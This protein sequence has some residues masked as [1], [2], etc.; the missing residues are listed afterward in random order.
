MTQL[1]PNEHANC[2]LMS[3]LVDPITQDGAPYESIKQPSVQA[4]IETTSDGI[5]IGFEGY[6]DHD[7]LEGYG[8][9]VN[10]E[11]YNDELVV[12]VWSNINSEE[13]THKIKLAGAQEIR[14][15]ADKQ[16]EA[17]QAATVLQPEPHLAKLMASQTHSITKME[18]G[19]TVTFS[20][21]KERL[22]V[23]HA[24]DG[25]FRIGPDHIAVGNVYGALLSYMQFAIRA[26]PFMVTA[27]V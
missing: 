11:Y 23:E 25:E 5:N 2:V 20:L 13:P 4:I 26:N 17:V 15:I 6:G 14:R 1:I 18:I 24:S 10:I 22:I 12:R 7:M 3:R 21:G 8:R 16:D 9:P 19:E 27:N